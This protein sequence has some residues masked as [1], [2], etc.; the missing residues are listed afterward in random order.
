MTAGVRIGGLQHR[1]GIAVDDDGGEGGAVARPRLVMAHVVP[2]AIAARVGI[3][4]G[5]DDGGRDCDQSEGKRPQRAR[6]SQG[7]AKHKLPRPIFCLDHRFVRQ[8]CAQRTATV[9][10]RERPVLSG[11]TNR[12]AVLA[13]VLVT[14]AFQAPARRRTTP[15]HRLGGASF[16]KIKEPLRRAPGFLRNLV[17]L[18]NAQFLLIFCASQYMRAHV[19]EP[20]SPDRNLN[21]SLERTP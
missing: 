12:T 4:C 6:G 10:L 19:T 13:K 17:A 21:F 2:S 11:P 8:N 9:T 16:Q 1:A 14:N 18:C 7:G 5:E 15:A 20:V 3:L